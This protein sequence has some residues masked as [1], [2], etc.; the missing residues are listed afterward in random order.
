MLKAV[1]IYLFIYLFVYLYIYLFIYTTHNR[2]V[3]SFTANVGFHVWKLTS[4]ENGLTFVLGTFEN[5]PTRA[6]SFAKGV[7]FQMAIYII[8]IK[9]ITLPKLCSLVDPTAGFRG[10][11]LG[12]GPNL[13]YSQLNWK[14]HGFIPLFFCGGPNSH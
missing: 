8:I 5:D 14:L 3:H 7:S 12:R 13:G 4:F 2:S 1:F 9:T 11:N 6:N 10:T